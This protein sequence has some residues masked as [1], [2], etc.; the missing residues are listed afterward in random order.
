MSPTL[1][2]RSSIADE[3][4][5]LGLRIISEERPGY[6]PDLERYH[7]PWRDDRS[8][9][10]ALARFH[11]DL[12]AAADVDPQGK[13]VLDAGCGYGFTLLLYGLLGAAE[14]HGIDVDEARVSTVDAYRELLPPDLESR[15][16]VALGDVAALEFADQSVDIL[17]SIEAV[18]VYLDLDAFVAEAARVLRPG[19]KLLIAEANNALN[20]R[21]RARTLDIWDAYERG[22]P[23]VEV[24]G[25][26][27]AK[28]Y[29]ER[30]EEIIRGADPAIGDDE[31]RA[32]AE[33]TSGMTK[34][35]ILAVIG[36][37]IPDSP[38]ERGRMPIAPEGIAVERM[39][40]PYELAAMLREHGLR[41][42]VRGYWG[43]AG[44]SPHVRAANALLGAGRRLTIR[45]AP[46]FRVI[47]TR[48]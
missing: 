3:L 10:D 4:Y 8:H 31:A 28:S 47:A 34:A 16:H 35:E 42:K 45:T 41:T 48:T 18:G 7:G 22:E 36:G 11:A 1:Q 32:L 30:R 27:I 13:I 24:H 25:H 19:G 15:L 6:D 29:V 40:D 23:G 46:A 17:L 44:G 38:Y 21:L 5:D 43:G 39:V 12:L 14:L 37:A 20:R 2:K 33:R 9:A 26:Q